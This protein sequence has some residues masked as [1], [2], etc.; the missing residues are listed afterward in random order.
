MQG[1][2]KNSYDQ[3]NEDLPTKEIQTEEIFYEDFENQCPED[4]FKTFAK[5]NEEN[6]DDYIN[7]ASTQKFLQ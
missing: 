5:K 1:G 4:F 3:S 6:D 7:L 2:L